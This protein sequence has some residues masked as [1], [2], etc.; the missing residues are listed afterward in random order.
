M[1]NRRG[2][3]ARVSPPSVFVLALIWFRFFLF[4]WLLL[5]RL[6]SLGLSWVCMDVRR[7]G[8]VGEEVEGK[9][10]LFLLWV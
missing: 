8:F 3:T 6:L 9:L 5:L 10:L 7:L 1:H 4:F 2:W